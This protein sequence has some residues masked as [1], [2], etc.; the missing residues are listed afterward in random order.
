MPYIEQDKVDAKTREKLEN[1]VD[2]KSTLFTCKKETAVYTT[3][4]PYD[5]N[6]FFKTFRKLINLL[7]NTPQVAF[8][9]PWRR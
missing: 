2:I 5:A 8:Q 6:L 1:V 7:F 4:A 3:A 9:Q